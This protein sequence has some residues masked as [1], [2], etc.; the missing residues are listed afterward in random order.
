MSVSSALPWLFPQRVGSLVTI[1]FIVPAYSIYV[2]VNLLTWNQQAKQQKRDWPSR[3]T[4]PSS[5]SLAQNIGRWCDV[6]LA[7]GCVMLAVT[8]PET[9]EKN[10]G[11]L[12]FLWVCGC[13]CIRFCVCVCVCVFYLCVSD[14]DDQAIPL[15][16]PLKPTMGVLCWYIKRG[17]KGGSRIM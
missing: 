17:R 4:H 16:W 10:T 3:C 2:A 13:V 11:Y 12:R 6:S 7:A 8:L 9:S 5:L 15:L 1:L 14:A